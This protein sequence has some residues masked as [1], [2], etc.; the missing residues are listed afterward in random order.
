MIMG[1]C[2]G[3]VIPPLMGMLADTVG[4]QN[5]SVMVIGACLCYLAAF[6][7]LGQGTGR[8]KVERHFANSAGRFNRFSL[9]LW[10]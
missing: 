7:T 10:R 1:V 6:F 5:G 4:N 2:G 3:A 9:F 8:K